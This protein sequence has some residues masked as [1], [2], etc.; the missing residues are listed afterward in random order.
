MVFHEVMNMYE[1]LCEILQLEV[2][3]FPKRR[4]MAPKFTPSRLKNIKT[5][6]SKAHTCKQLA[7]IFN[8]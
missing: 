3:F 5:N 4:R 2:C 7:H 8:F 6:L 1:G